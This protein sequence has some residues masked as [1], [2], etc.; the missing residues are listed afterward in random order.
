MVSIRDRTDEH[1]CGGVLVEP[2]WVLTA[3]HCVDPDFPE[4]AGPAPVVVI[5][6]CNLRDT[7]KNANGKVEVS[8]NWYVSCT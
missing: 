1:K 3:A 6:V 4:S 7:K 2:Q 5:G 8:L